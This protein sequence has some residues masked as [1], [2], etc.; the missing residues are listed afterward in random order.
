MAITHTK[1][2]GK[3]DGGD[4]TLVQPSDWNASHT[5]GAATIT[6]AMIVNLSTQTVL[7]RNTAGAGVSEE[8]TA[9]QL[10]DWLS[11]STGAILARFGAGSWAPITNVATDGSDL[12]VTANASPSAPAAGKVQLG[13]TNVGGLIMASTLAPA[14]AVSEIQAMLG[15]KRTCGWMPACGSPTPTTWGFEALRV[16]GTATARTPA[17]TSLATSLT[18]LGA[19]SAAG[20]GSACGFRGAAAQFFLGNAAGRGGF[21]YIA[22]FVISDAALVATANTFVGLQ[23]ATG[24]PSDVAPSTLTNLIG[25]G[26]DNGDTA[27][28]LYASGAAAQ[29]R[30][31]LGA[32]FPVNTVSTDVYELVLYAVPNASAVSYLVTR[33][34]TGHTASGSLSGANI[35]TNTTFLAPNWYR[36]NG[37]TATAVAL[38]LVNAYAQID[39]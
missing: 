33:I 38:D 5:I 28:Q 10:L 24:A 37:G 3:A 31:S 27:L 13:A 35:P 34:N 36:S 30:V 9:G 11:S 7:G 39:Y 19:V 32:N 25:V 12:V 20:A 15:R 29:A 18:R 1:V 23:N 26:C 14:G 2:S 22:R 8:V 21:L 6:K 16:T 17:S 4:A